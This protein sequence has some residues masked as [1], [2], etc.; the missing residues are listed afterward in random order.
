MLQHIRIHVVWVL[1]SKLIL[2]R[3]TCC[4]FGLDIHIIDRWT[5]FDYLSPSINHYLCGTEKFWLRFIRQHLYFNIISRPLWWLGLLTLLGCALGSIYGFWIKIVF[6]LAKLYRIFWKEFLNCNL[7]TSFIRS[8]IKLAQSN[9]LTG[10]WSW[11][12][13]FRVRSWFCSSVSLKFGDHGLHFI[14]VQ[15][16]LE[17]VYTQLHLPI[18]FLH[19]Y[20]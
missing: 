8:D 5:F 3:K 17:C 20:Y 11:F 14:A 13:I 7:I 1:W 4:H 2:S 19:K 9:Y 10:S 6:G 18:L 12:A 16:H 15:K